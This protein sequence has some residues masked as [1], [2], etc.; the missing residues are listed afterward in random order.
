[1]TEARVSHSTL[2]TV[3][4]VINLVLGV[5]LV[6]FPGHLV[7][8]LGIPSTEVA[9]YPSILGAVLFGIGI[10]LLIE[11]ARGGSGLGLAGAVSINLCGGA[12]LIAW[13]L[14][15]SLSVP[16]R[17]RLLLW[18]LAVLLVGLS[19]LELAAHVRRSAG[20]SP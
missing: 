3:D 12:A 7:S 20:T 9:F 15:G 14:F 8:A 16:A 19:S 5:L 17:G 1:M 6:V 2:L 18:A 10:A 13:L 4:A 11:R